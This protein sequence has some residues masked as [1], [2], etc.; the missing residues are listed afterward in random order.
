MARTAEESLRA[1]LV[2]HGLARPVDKIAWHALG[3]GV[4]S[5]IWRA[6]LPGRSLCIKRALARLRVK[7]PWYAPVERNA[8]EWAW[9]E[10]VGAICPRVVPKLLAHDPARGM[11]AMAYLPPDRYPLWKNRLLAGEVDRA[12]AAAAGDALG[13]IHAATAGDARIAARFCTDEAFHA[14]RIEPYLL[15]TAERHPDLRAQLRS[16]AERTAALHVALV[17]GDVSPKNILIGPEGPVFLDAET[18]WYGDPAFDLAF[19]LNHLLLKALVRPEAAD[20]L[21]VSFSAFREAYRAR[22]DWEPCAGLEARAASLLPALML[23]RVD[24]KSPV[25]YLNAAA[26]ERVRAFATARMRVEDA[27]LSTAF[28]DWKAFLRARA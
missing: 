20:A 14:L 7:A 2:A 6:D 1:F 28:A 18:A 24:G 3:G 25:E 15:A 8:T 19:C 11:F 10:T 21:E 16:L 12:F 26:Q 23:A 13:H 4:S 17:H 9:F 5:D 27:A 22:L